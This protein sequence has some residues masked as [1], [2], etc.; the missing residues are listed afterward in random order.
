MASTNNANVICFPELCI[1]EEWVDEAKNLY[2]NN[3][4]VFGSFYKNAFNTCPIIIQGQV[5]YI[6]KITP[7]PHDESDTGTGRCMKSGREI[8]IF[9][10]KFGRLAVL[11]CKD[12]LNE[13]HK[14]VYNP[15]IEK[16]KVDFIIVPSRNRAVELFQKRGDLVCQEDH[17]PYVLQINAVKIVEENDAGGT[18]IIGMDHAGALNRYREEN[19]KPEDGIKYKLFE[20]SGEMVIAADLDISRKGAPVPATDFKMKKPVALRI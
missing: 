6:Q 15:D 1:D 17:L 16:N 18:C 12:F 8:L 9:Q 13:V 3:I 2:K 20:A 10:T 14:I 5:Y 11:L 7:S 19:W 4:I